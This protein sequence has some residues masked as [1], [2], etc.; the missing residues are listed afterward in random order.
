MAT[1]DEIDA[2]RACPASVP[3][4]KMSGFN[5]ILRKDLKLEL[6]SGE[7]TITLV[8]LSLLILIV[9]TFALN[10]PAD[11][12]AIAAAALWVAMIFAGT[13]GAT[14]TLVGEWQNGCIRGLLL[15]PVDRATIYCAKLVASFLFM[16]T[17]E[18]AAAVL[19]VLFFNLNF[20]LRLVHLAPVLAM[21]TLG[22]AALATLMATIPVQMRAGDL[23][24]PVLA[25]P[26]F[27]PALIAGVKASNTALAGLPFAAF[28]QWLKVLGVC[29][30]LFL[31][32][33]YL[34]F[35]HVIAED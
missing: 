15:S 17:A 22:F 31:S 12:P 20:D 21:G 35:E 27:V 23:L 13:I 25:V 5:A 24:L 6:R 7:S 8:F 29:D 19:V 4:F 3:V 11:D 1:A 10:A 16:A 28:T 32:V 2:I 18:I 14:R 30:I 34:L 33:G 9:L 26:L